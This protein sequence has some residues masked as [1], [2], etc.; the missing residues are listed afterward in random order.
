MLG[1]I[2]IYF[3]LKNQVV[4]NRINTISCYISYNN[5]YINNYTPSFRVVQKKSCQIFFQCVSKKKT[6]I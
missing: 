3:N 5:S 2:Q 6:M 4:R 1:T